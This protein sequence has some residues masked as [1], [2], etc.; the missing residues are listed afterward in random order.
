MKPAATPKGPKQAR[1]GFNPPE[2]DTPPS[3][4]LCRLPHAWLHTFRRFLNLA[5]AETLCRACFDQVRTAEGNW[6]LPL[7]RFFRLRSK[8]QMCNK[9]PA[10]Y[11]ICLAMPGTSDL[12]LAA[13]TIRFCFN[14]L[15]GTSTG[16]EAIPRALNYSVVLKIHLMPSFAALRSQGNLLTSATSSRPTA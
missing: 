15:Q 16:L 7:A 8:K 13:A 5:L 2:N 9:A 6:M 14:P 3:V 11:L 10:A 4:V 1:D 12:D